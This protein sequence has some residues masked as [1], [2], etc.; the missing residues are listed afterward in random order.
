MFSLIKVI[1]LNNPSKTL[2]T[3]KAEG[4]SHPVL[5]GAVVK[6]EGWGSKE[7]RKLGLIPNPGG[8]PLPVPSASWCP[9][10]RAGDSNVPNTSHRGRPPRLAVLQ[11]LIVLALLRFC[12]WE[13]G[14]PET[15]VN[16][17]ST[18]STSHGTAWIQIYFI[19]FW[20]FRKTR[21]LGSDCFMGERWKESET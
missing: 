9:G 14:T 5:L 6:L 4:N 3:L 8:R 2:V 20:F 16:F 19:S 1:Y 13:F 10:N 12:P 11:I 18:S 21:L 17:D 15:N 7:I